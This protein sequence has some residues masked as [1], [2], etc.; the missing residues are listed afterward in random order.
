MI[1]S[2]TISLS[3]NPSFVGCL[4]SLNLLVDGKEISKLSGGETHKFDLDPG[5]HKVQIKPWGSAGSELIELNVA[6]GQSTKL[7]CGLTQ[8]YRCVWTSLLAIMLLN[9][10]AIIFA[11]TASNTCIVAFSAVC[12]ILLLTMSFLAYKRGGCFYLR[13]VP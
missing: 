10:F 8:V 11:G 7:E 9:Q 5:H 4:G 6:P 1:D 3:R 13:I 12:S 2:G